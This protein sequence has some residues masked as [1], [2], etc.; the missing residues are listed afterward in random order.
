MKVLRASKLAPLA[1]GLFAREHDAGITTTRIDIV[2]VTGAVETENKAAMTR[3]GIRY[4]TLQRGGK[5]LLRGSGRWRLLRQRALEAAT[6]ER[7]DLI[8]PF[9]GIQRPG[10]GWLAESA[11][12]VL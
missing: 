5:S 7:P 10:G 9:T 12:R 1:H 2:A 11:Y 6:A 3:S 4:R 8:Q